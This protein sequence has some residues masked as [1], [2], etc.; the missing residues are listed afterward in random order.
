MKST[1]LFFFQFFLVVHVFSQDT[2]IL[3]STE[4]SSVKS[5]E[6]SLNSVNKG[7]QFFDPYKDEDFEDVYDKWPNVTTKPLI[8][9][10]TNDSFFPPLHVW[11]FYDKDSTVKWIYYHWGFGNTDVEASESEIKKQILRF[12][13]YKEKYFLEKA[14]LVIALGN[15]RENDLIIDTPDYYQIKSVWNQID[16]R[17][18]I[19]MVFAKKPMEIDDP[20]LNKKIILPIS[21]VEIKI[22]LKEL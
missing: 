8:Y 13:E 7:F 4:L 16:K 3:K 18:V 10:R 12:I 6:D 19:N 15:P 22:L 1:G 5:L 2:L 14:K 20:V 17:I 21:K 11:Y 9:K